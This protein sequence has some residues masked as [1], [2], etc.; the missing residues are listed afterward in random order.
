MKL[1]SKCKLQIGCRN[2]LAISLQLMQNRLNVPA[3]F[4]FRAR[5]SGRRLNEFKKMRGVLSHFLTIN[6]QSCPATN[7]VRASIIKST[8][9]HFRSSLPCRNARLTCVQVATTI[10]SKASQLELGNQQEITSCNE[11]K[12]V[13]SNI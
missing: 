9:L 13:E 12:Y 4:V 11:Y 10:G 8:V 6:I 5:F 2:K 1:I 7:V 3:V